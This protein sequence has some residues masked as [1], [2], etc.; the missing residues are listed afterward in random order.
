MAK[1][2]RN[3]KEEERVVSKSR[4]AVMSMSC[5]FI[6]TSSSAASSP[7]ASES[8]AM[9]IAPGKPDSRMSIEPNSFDAASTSQVRLKDA[10][11]GGLM[12]RQRWN[13]SHQEKEDSEDSDNPEAETGYYKGELVAQNSKAWGQPFAQ[14]TWR[15][16][17]RFEC[18]FG[19]LGNAHEYHSSSSGSSRKRLWHEYKELS[20]EN[21]GTDFQRNR[22]TD[23]WS[24]RNHWHK[25]DQFPR[26]E[27]GIDKLIAESSLSI[28]HCQSLCL[29]RLCAVFGK[30]WRQSRGSQK[31]QIQLYSDD[32]CVSEL[33]RI[34]GQPMEFE[35]K[36]FPGFTTVGILSEIQQMMG[37][38]QCE[39]ENFTN[40]IIFMSKF[41]DIVWDAQ[42]NDE[43]CAKKPMTIKECAEWFPRG[44]WSFQGLGSE[45][46][47]YGTYDCKPDGSWNR[48]AEK[49]LQNFAGSGHPIFRCTSALDRGQMR[50]KEGGK[51]SIHF[52]AVRKALSCF[53]RWSSP[54]IS[55]VFSEQ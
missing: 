37:K 23:Q 51:T 11:L 19:Y 36:I 45:K 46:K 9:P 49:M 35:W 27:V 2:S 13:P 16:N 24:E 12:E 8:P 54:S 31:K 21:N 10:S 50:S 41:N 5:Y 39:P 4:P 17:E 28:F 34:D 18:E 15:P 25:P 3:Q 47:W 52:N 20:L 43:L 26:F 22:K 29:L 7:I 53:S 32:N 48:T 55:S 44:H 33:N 30:N 14:K 38:W 6:A 40:R 42:G 1:R